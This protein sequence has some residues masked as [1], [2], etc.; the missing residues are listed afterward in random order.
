MLLHT[1]SP[2]ALSKKRVDDFIIG[3]CITVLDF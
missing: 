2:Y 3:F 1:L